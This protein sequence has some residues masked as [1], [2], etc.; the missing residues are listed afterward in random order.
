L[1]INY[2]KLKNK[3]II[4]FSKPELALLFKNAKIDESRQEMRRKGISYDDLRNDKCKILEIATII[5]S[6]AV[7]DKNEHEIFSALYIYLDFFGRDSK[8][9]FELKN[10]F[11][12]GKDIIQNLSDLKKATE[13][14]TLSDFII[15]SKDGFR[16]F[17]LKRYRGRLRTEDILGFI[18]KK[19]T[20]YGKDLGCANLL[21]VLQPKT[22]DLPEVNFKEIYEK[23]KGFK[24]KSIGQILISYNEEDKIYVINQVYPDLNTVSIPINYNP[25]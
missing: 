15:K 19:L 22:N 16:S 6:R 2:I 18:E 9:C 13:E 25:E 5:S 11:N 4:C 20:H 1:K 10:N 23:A 7:E 24:I 14:K 8:V 21:I 12:T 17:Q 3:N